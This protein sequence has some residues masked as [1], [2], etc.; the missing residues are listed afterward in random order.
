MAPWGQKSCG[1]RRDAT[2]HALYVAND[3]ACFTLCDATEVRRGK[4]WYVVKVPRGEHRRLDGPPP[5]TLN[6]EGA[7]GETVCRPGRKESL[8]QRYVGGK[9]PAG[10][11]REGGITYLTLA[12]VAVEE[13]HVRYGERRPSDDQGAVWQ[14]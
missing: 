14:P 8:L 6:F 5:P 2:V 10:T 1:R 13:S 12:G 4:Q 3:R 11:M 9:V 7:R